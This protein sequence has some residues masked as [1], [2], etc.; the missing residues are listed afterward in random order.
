MNRNHTW[1]LPRRRLD[2]LA[3]MRM[4]LTASVNHL[5]TVDLWKE[6]VRTLWIDAPKKKNIKS[7]VTKFFL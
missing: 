2:I 4:L 1:F 5:L 7:F 6:G 3:S